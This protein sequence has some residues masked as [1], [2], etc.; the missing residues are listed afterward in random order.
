MS[1]CLCF[2]HSGSKNA[3]RATIFSL[4]PPQAALE[5]V[6]RHAVETRRQTRQPFQVPQ[7]GLRSKF[8]SF[9]PRHVA[10]KLHIACSDFLQKS[11]CAHFATSPFSQNVTLGPKRPR[12]RRQLS[13][14]Y[15]SSNP[16][17]KIAKASLPYPFYK[18]GS[19]Q[20]LVVQ[21]FEEFFFV[22]SAKQKQ[23]LP[24]WGNDCFCL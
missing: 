2:S 17:I 3:C 18:R 15:D 22:A 1:V 10:D 5:Y 12:C 14:R 8:K 4:Y 23:S 19:P 24:F 13:A 21:G 9:L 6:A 16:F 7:E 20:N 11:P